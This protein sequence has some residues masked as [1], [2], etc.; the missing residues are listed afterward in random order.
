[1]AYAGLDI[2][3]KICLIPG[4]T[5]GLGRSIALGYAEAGATVI[6]GST[7][8]DKVDVMRKELGAGHDAVRLDVSDA[9]SVQSAIDTVIKKYGRI[10]AMVNAAG[11]LKRQPTL[12]MPVEQFERIIRINLVGSFIIAQAIGRVMKDQAPDAAGIRGSIVNIA[13]ISSFVALEGVCAYGCSKAGV[14]ALTKSLA[15]DWA[16][17]GIRVN[18]I[19]PGFFPTPINRSIIEGTPRGDWI[20]K[21]TP[22]GRFGKGDELVGAAIYLISPA[23][24]FTTGETLVVDG[25]FLAKGI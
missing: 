3:G 12:E 4:G 19:A 16:Q 17:Y 8:L 11:V 13:S 10:D 2:S 22:A 6:A 23:A 20:I 24:S 14:M 9:A 1:M 15:N 5:S 7:N 21:H 25:G 18:A